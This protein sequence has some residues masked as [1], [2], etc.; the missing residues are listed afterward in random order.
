MR[1]PEIEGL[2]PNLDH[3]GAVAV[4]LAKRGISRFGRRAKL[5]WIAT[6]TVLGLLAA[7]GLPPLLSRT[8]AGSGVVAVGVSELSTA[9]GGFSRTLPLPSAP[10]GAA[11]GDGSVWVT[12][13]EGHALYRIDLLTGLTG[14]RSR[15][16]QAP[17]RSLWR[18]RMYGSPTL[19]TEP[20]PR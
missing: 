7:F 19:W 4:P 20:F 15:S 10:G 14:T 18:V 16:V 3:A 2:S 13:P 1:P 17:E 5:G 11:S 9:N 6:A 12:S 8:P